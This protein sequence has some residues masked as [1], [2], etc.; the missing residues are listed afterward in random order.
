MEQ[1]AVI[2]PLARWLE[3]VLQA[4]LQR[5]EFVRIKRDL[6]TSNLRRQT[7]TLYIPL[8]DGLVRGSPR[9]AAR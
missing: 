3:R 2:L 7:R 9:C 8:T 1:M 4:G 5:D 6:T